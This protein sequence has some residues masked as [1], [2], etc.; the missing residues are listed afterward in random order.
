MNNYIRKIKEYEKEKMLLITITQKD[1]N[2]KEIREVATKLKELTG[3]QVEF[4]WN[5]DSPH[6]HI[7]VELPDNVS[8]FQIRNKEVL[9]EYLKEPYM[10]YRE[11]QWKKKR[12]IK[13]YKRK[14][15]EEQFSESYVQFMDVNL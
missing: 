11:T 6:S 12:K 3:K 2:E 4:T 8:A 15:E 14:S 9:E 13:H 7:A 5:T 10:P 1:I